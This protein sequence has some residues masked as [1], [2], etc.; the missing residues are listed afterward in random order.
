M[1]EPA[2]GRIRRCLLTARTHWGA[3]FLA[4]AISLPTIF[5]VAELVFQLYAEP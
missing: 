5:V 4:A 3:L 2:P 1:D